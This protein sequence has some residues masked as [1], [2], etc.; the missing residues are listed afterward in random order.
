[1]ERVFVDL[2]AV[3]PNDD[4]PHEE[5]SFEELR[6]QS[7]GWLGMKWRAEYTNVSS[8]ESGANQDLQQ[9]PSP[10]PEEIIQKNVNQL[11][12]R[13]SVKPERLASG[14]DLHDEPR[15]REMKV[16]RPKKMKIMEVKGET[17]TS[18]LTSQ[19]FVE[20]R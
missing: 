10:A 4:D 11:T 12:A 5:M 19:E 14:D 16:G 20:G 18:K 8:R 1:M 17:Q 9:A 15:A 13:D 6:A 2:R 3:Y 7:R